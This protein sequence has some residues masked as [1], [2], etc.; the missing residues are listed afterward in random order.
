[1]AD[2]PQQ[3]SWSDEARRVLS[4]ARASTNDLAEYQQQVTTGAAQLWRFP[5]NR[6]TY[7]LTRVEQYLSG[8]CDLVMVAGA[9]E[10]AA[11]VIQWAGALAEREGMSLRVHIVRPGLKRLLEKYGCY[12]SEIVMRREHG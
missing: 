7:L 4:A 10:K 3:V 6:S 9:G 11:Q 12:Q 1:M 8:D 2:I 5:F